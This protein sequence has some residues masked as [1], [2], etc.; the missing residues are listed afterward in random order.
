MIYQKKPNGTDEELKEISF[1]EALPLAGTGALVF[2][3]PIEEMNFYKEVI[4]KYPPTPAMPKENKKN[5]FDISEILPYL[6]DA[7]LHEIVLS[8]V[9]DAENSEYKNLDLEELLPFLNEKDTDLLFVE[10]ISNHNSKIKPVDLAP[11]VSE[12]ALTVF[13]DEYLKG[14]YQDVD[15]D[16]LYPFMKSSDIKR[17]FIHFLEQKEKTEKE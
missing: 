11:F 17:L 1:E 16:D 5:G 4:K 3:S 15:I 6:D 2:D 9:N 8:I 7:Q 10:G 14:N 12:N 13:V